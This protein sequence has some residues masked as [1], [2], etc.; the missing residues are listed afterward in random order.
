MR[1]PQEHSSKTLFFVFAGMVSMIAFGTASM[2]M[3]ALKGILPLAVAP[4]ISQYAKTEYLKYAADD[5]TGE[6]LISQNAFSWR[7]ETWSNSDQPYRQVRQQ[8]DAA[9]NSGAKP[10][11]LA[12]EYQKQAQQ[13]RGAALA[14]F[15]WGYA[16]WKTLTPI[17]TWDEKQINGLGDFFVLANTASPNTYDYSRLRYLVSYQSNDQVDLGERL[18]LHDPQDL[19]V[20]AHLA[21]DYTA[22]SSEPYNSKVKSRAVQL[23]KQLIQ[24]KPAYSRYYAILAEAYTASYF[25][26]GKHR[27]D[28]AAAIAALKKYLS[29]AKPD[30]Y[31]YQ[32]AKTRLADLEQRIGVDQ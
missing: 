3:G 26:N 27:Q 10:R 11:Q 22:P 12:F 32:G 28:A 18:L 5:P 23:S 31:F 16:L 8:V 2:H 14:Q 29:L 15:R 6:D 9:I 24:A 25:T 1:P 30:E 13:D 19:D 7:H 17:S 4:S 20:K 21:L